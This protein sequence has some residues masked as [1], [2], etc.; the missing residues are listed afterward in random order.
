MAIVRVRE[1]VNPLGIRFSKAI[2]PPKWE[3]IFDAVDRPWHLDIGC[4]RGYF[5]LKIATERPH[6]NVVGLEIREP[7]VD[8]ANQW[9]DEA[10]LRNLHY[11]SCNANNS[12]RPILESLPKGAVQL[13]SVQF[14]DPWF[15]KRHQKRRV[16]Q[17]PLVDELALFLP[18]GAQVFLQ[19]D[20]EE[21][22]REMGDRFAANPAF[23]KT[24][25][26]D[27]LPENPLPVR[28]EREIS[29]IKQGLPVYRTQ[30]ERV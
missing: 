12:V 23:Q 2:S 13:V 18:M 16:V 11:L 19:S 22:A 8:R 15:K 10:G 17:P 14:P 5:P 27:W 3:E 6:W 30:L 7:L 4:A 24:H 20:V 9:R 25:D 1:H 26:G 29:V 21:V 28:T